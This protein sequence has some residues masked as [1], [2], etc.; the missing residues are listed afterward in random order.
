[1]RVKKGV[2]KIAIIVEQAVIHTERATSALD[3]YEITLEAVPPG[4]HETKIIPTAK[5]GGKSKILAIP[6]PKKGIIRN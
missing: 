1:M 3:K 2:I 4:Q 5:R 6:H